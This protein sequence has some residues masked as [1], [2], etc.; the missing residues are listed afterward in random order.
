M[1]GSFAGA[2]FFAPSPRAT[3][4]RSRAVTLPPASAPG[5]RAP[6]VIAEGVALPSLAERVGCVLGE[7]SFL[8]GSFAGAAF[9][10][11]SP[12]ATALRSRAVTLPLASAPGRRAPFV[13]AERVVL[14]S[15]AERVGCV[16]GEAPFLTGSFAGAAF[17]APSPRATALRSRAVTLPL[18][19]A[20]GRRAPFV[21]AER[22]VPPSLAERVVP[23]SLADVVPPSLADVVPPSLADVVPPSLA[24][25]LV[26][27]RWP[28]VSSRRRWPMSSRRRWPMS[29]RRRWPM[30]SRR[31]WPMSSR[32]R[33]PMS[34]RRRWPMSSRRAGRTSRPAVAG[35]T[36]RPAV[37][38]RT[39]RLPSPAERLDLPSPAERVDLPSPAEDVALSSDLSSARRRVPLP[40]AWLAPREPPRRR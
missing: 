10:A 8:T 11:P 29:S 19:S 2:A 34:S 3:A 12:R 35:R 20:P 13:V 38:G 25:R 21:I 7:A 28:N 23:P 22:V 17:F 9:F 15:L 5:R 27:R 32:R 14:P 36:S 31:R 6:F 26:R 40:G 37:A 24:E 33:W 39:S 18:A 16:L 1:T 4:L 30:S